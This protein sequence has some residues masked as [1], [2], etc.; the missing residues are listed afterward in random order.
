MA[1]LDELRRDAKHLDYEIWMLMETAERLRG[2]KPMPDDEI[3]K[4]AVLESWLVH[5]RILMEFFS[6]RAGPDSDNVQ[7]V[8]YV[9]GS[10]AKRRL[11]AQQPRKGSREWKRVK[12]IHKALAHLARDRDRLNTDWNEWD[13]EMVTSRLRSFFEVLPPER[14]LWFP[15]A[16]K[17]FAGA[18]SR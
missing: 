6:N 14:R 7:A 9:S 5:V 3:A 13:L 4:R 12:E 16:S 11:R 15:K 2:D 10:S 1:T 17:W 8:H 18:F